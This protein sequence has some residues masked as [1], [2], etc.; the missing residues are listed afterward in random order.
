MR[1]YLTAQTFYCIA[2]LMQGISN[3]QFLHQ[4]SLAPQTKAT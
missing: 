3:Q 1:Q 4:K 2:I